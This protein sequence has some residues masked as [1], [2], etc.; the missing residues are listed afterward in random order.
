MHQRSRTMILA[1]IVAV[2]A[3]S[4]TATPAHADAID[5]DWCH[6]TSHL[7]INGDS[8]V[9]PGRNKIQGQYTRYSFVYIVPV[10]EPGAGNEVSMVMVRGQELVQLKRS[11][12]DGEPEVWRR[13]KPIS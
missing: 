1:A 7:A 12:Q 9:T 5:G 2:S 6:G 8:I 3:A 13:C 4:L 11:G 10:N